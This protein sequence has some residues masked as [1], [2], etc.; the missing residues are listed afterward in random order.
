MFCCLDCINAGEARNDPSVPILPQATRLK[1]YI[2]HPEEREQHVSSDAPALPKQLLPLLPRDT[3][4]ISRMWECAIPT[5]I[6]P[7]HFLAGIIWT[8]IKNL[9]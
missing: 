5:F 7:E 1:G 6:N 3:P 9:F 8:S 4:Y 2:L